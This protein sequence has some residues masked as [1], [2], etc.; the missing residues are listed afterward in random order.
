MQRMDKR[1]DKIVLQ[2][3]DNGILQLLLIFIIF[4]HFLSIPILE[5]RLYE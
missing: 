2:R 1:V 3:H 4:T 5:E